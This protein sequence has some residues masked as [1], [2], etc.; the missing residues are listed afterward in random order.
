MQRYKSNSSFEEK[1]GYCRAVS[2]GTYIHVSGTTGYDYTSMSISPN[3]VEQAEQCMQNIGDA[4]EVFDATFADI[5]RVHYYCPEATDFEVCWPV[6]RRY[7][8]QTPPA[9][10]MLAVPLL[11]PEMKIEIEVTAR[12]PN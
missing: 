9:A 7:F 2:D 12:C 10:T 4:L 6:F 1:I 11:D 3:V 5:V 8:E